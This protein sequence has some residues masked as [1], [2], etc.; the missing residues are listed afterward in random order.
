MTTTAAPPLNPAP[1]RSP[2]PKVLSSADADADAKIAAFD[3]AL[4]M[5]TRG[6]ILDYLEAKT[7]LDLATMR[8]VRS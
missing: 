4:D 3:R 2:A 6:I 5:H 8:A 1:A 7:G